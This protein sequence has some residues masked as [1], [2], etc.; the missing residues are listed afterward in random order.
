MPEPEGSFEVRG[1]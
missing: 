1:C